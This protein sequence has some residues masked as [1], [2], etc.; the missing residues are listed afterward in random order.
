[1]R[2]RPKEPAHLVHTIAALA[3]TRGEDA[4]DLGASITANA[5][6]AFGLP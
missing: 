1:V 2:A 6:R 4:D 5:A 3:D